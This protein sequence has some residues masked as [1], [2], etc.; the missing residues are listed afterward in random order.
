M[1]KA[2][3]ELISVRTNEVDAGDR[4]IFEQRLRIESSGLVEA[5]FAR[6]M[7][8]KSSDFMGLLSGRVGRTPIQETASIEQS[9]CT[10]S[11]WKPPF[12]TM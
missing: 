10:A 5:S 7:R 11:R 2:Y 8:A 9:A 3:P 1:C 4:L 6:A 12:R